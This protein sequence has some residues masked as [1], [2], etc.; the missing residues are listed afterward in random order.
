MTPVTEVVPSAENAG[1]FSY[2]VSFAPFERNLLMDTYSA[3]GLQSAS[4]LASDD[5]EV[6]GI[7][8]VL[9]DHWLPRIMVEMSFEFMMEDLELPIMQRPSAEDCVKLYRVFLTRL[10]WPT[11][12][13]SANKYRSE[14][15]ESVNPI[16]L[17]QLQRSPTL[18]F[19]ENIDIEM[20]LV[21]DLSSWKILVAMFKTL[22]AE[23]ICWTSYMKESGLDESFEVWKVVRMFRNRVNRPDGISALVT[24]S[25]NHEDGDFQK[26]L[27][28][29]YQLERTR[30]V[31]NFS[32]MI[33]QMKKDHEILHELGIADPELLSRTEVAQVCTAST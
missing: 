27:L 9:F 28:E 15:A 32:D 13:S 17:Y 31:A 33:G 16:F 24:F 18:Q 1:N 3:C 11:S 7:I 10:A 20:N 26:T 29:R 21:D 12:G 6:T 23:M 4:Q 25:K 2:I 8:Q 14:I 19:L 22:E 30:A 5:D